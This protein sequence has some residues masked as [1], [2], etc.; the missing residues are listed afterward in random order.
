ML[1]SLTAS[2]QATLEGLPRFPRVSD[3]IHVE[4]ARETGKKAVE[5]QR[6]DSRSVGVADLSLGGLGLEQSV[7]LL[8][9]G[10]GRVGE[11]D[12]AP[13]ADDLLSSVRAHEAVEA[14]ALM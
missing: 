4:Q 1:R 8:A 2:R 10:V 12:G 13:L 5:E 7:Q 6:R 9:L 3:L 14:R 11:L